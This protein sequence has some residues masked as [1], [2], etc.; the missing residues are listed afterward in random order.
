MSKVVRIPVFDLDLSE[1]IKEYCFM[2][3]KEK[4]NECERREP[5]LTYM[6]E[7]HSHLQSRG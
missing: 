3:R 7:S 4:Q 6:Y 1:R 2:K 5:V